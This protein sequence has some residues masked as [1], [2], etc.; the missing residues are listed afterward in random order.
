[1]HK[2]FFSF[3]HLHLLKIVYEYLSVKNNL[4]FNRVL[5]VFFFFFFRYYFKF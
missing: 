4:N 1:M 3:Q 5:R 2:T